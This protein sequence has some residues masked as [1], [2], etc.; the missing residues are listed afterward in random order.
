[1][2]IKQR[3]KLFKLAIPN[4][5]KIVYV[6]GKG[7]GLFADRNFKKGET[8]IHFKA[9]LVATSKASPEAVTVDDK[10]CI[11]TKWLVPEAFINH[12]CSA[13]TKI[14]VVGFRYIAIKNIRKNEEITYDYNTT[15]YDM[16][17]SGDDFQCECGS[18]N[19]LGRIRGFKYLTRA[20]KMKLK[21]YLTPFL[22]KLTLVTKRTEGYPLSTQS[23][24]IKLLNF[25]ENKEKSFI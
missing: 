16:K 8:V 1:M 24:L 9:D 17:K 7:L 15:E 13:N 3:D 11:D 5:L 4:S 20:Q 18:K 6:W 14:D 10:F 22:I 2:L 23:G 25:M 12:S 21:P 19:C